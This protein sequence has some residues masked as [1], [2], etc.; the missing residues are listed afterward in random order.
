[1]PQSRATVA[2]RILQSLADQGRLA[3][4]PVSVLVSSPDPR[5][6][7]EWSLGR[8]LKADCVSQQ[9]ATDE[10]EQFAIDMLAS[11]K[12]R[13]PPGRQSP[14][15][16]AA[17]VVV[18]SPSGAK[19]KYLPRQENVY[20]ALFSLADLTESVRGRPGVTRQRFVELSANWRRLEAAR[21]EST[22][23]LLP[24]PMPFE[25][26]PSPGSRL[27]GYTSA[28][29]PRHSVDLMVVDAC[30]LRA[31][32]AEDDGAQAAT[33]VESSLLASPHLLSPS[34]SL[35]VVCPPAAL[36]HLNTARLTKFAK[37]RFREAYWA[38]RQTA[39]AEAMSYLFCSW[40]SGESTAHLA[41]DA[42]FPGFRLVGVR[43]D[44]H[45]NPH[46]A[47]SGAKAN[48]VASLRPSFTDAQQVRDTLQATLDREEKAKAKL[49]EDDEAFFG[50]A[51][52]M[53]K[54]GRHYT[55]PEN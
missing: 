16:D 32:D 8:R 26:L 52:D 2:V 42:S 7:V 24:A 14:E 38:R 25:A 51:F 40:L 31:C 27:G 4:I 28:L 18:L 49:Q 47:P 9:R 22:V 5:P 48:F 12:K 37:W 29:F 30:P 17:Q 21:R 44:K 39:G 36:A 55:Q 43:R 10:R 23:V 33:E 6:I 3:T 15:A 1:M 41:D 20:L 19:A 13:D 34:G 54:T 50:V 35:L 46:A 45:W 11:L 53:V